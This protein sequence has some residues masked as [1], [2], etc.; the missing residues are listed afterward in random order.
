MT[1]RNVSFPTSGV[2]V[3]AFS[4]S[5]MWTTLFGSAPLSPEALD[6]AQ[7]RGLTE[8]TVMEQFSRLGNTPYELAELTAEITGSVFAPASLL[9]RMRREATEKLEEFQSLPPVRAI[10]P[11]PDFRRT[12]PP[13]TAAAPTP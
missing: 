4:R 10:H 3:V 9:N 5:M 6:V 8:E 1:V 2:A 13:P 12:A 11:T 7:N